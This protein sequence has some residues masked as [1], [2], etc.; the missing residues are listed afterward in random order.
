LRDLILAFFSHWFCS[1]IEG[2]KTSFVYVFMCKVK[3]EGACFL[4]L[5][6][7]ESIPNIGNLMET[8]WE[9][10]GNMLGTKEK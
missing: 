6:G 1:P 2:E 8:H 5:C 9:L 7:N 4:M 10:E 3:H